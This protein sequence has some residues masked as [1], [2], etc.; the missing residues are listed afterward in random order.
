MN[1]NDDE[2]RAAE[3]SLVKVYM[4]LTGASESRARGVFMHICGDENG[5]KPVNGNGMNPMG[6]Q[7]GKRSV[8]RT[9]STGD[10]AAPGWTQ[11]RAPA[12]PAAPGA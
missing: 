8:M 1:L 3:L 2:G 7:P 10:E 9:S 12:M 4:D 11:F 6:F 5:V